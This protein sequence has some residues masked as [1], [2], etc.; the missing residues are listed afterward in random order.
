MTALDVQ[1]E[2]TYLDLC[3]CFGLQKLK[4]LL[5]KEGPAIETPLITFKHPNLFLFR[6]ILLNVKKKKKRERE[7]EKGN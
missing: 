5:M 7:R 6:K 4:S 2:I 1:K 3:F